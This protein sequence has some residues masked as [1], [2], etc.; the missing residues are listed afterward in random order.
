MY[1]K[2]ATDLDFVRREKEIEKFWKDEDIFGESIR[3]REGK[4]MYMFSDG[5]P[6][7][8]GKPHIGHV[9]TRAIKDMIP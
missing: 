4:P 9:L 7:A 8:N 6:A 3:I 1:K 2:V 5:P